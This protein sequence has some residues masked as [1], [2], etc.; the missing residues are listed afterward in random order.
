MAAKKNLNKN[1]DKKKEKTP[2]NK[3][4]TPSGYRNMSEKLHLKEKTL[5]LINSLEQTKKICDELREMRRSNKL[6]DSGIANLSRELSNNLKFAKRY[7]E[8]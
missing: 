3:S 5:E 6:S 1:S 2:K 8:G 4:V 7:A